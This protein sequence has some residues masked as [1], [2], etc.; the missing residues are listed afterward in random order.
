M[1]TVASAGDPS[2]PCYFRS[3]AKPFQA[4]PLL[5]SGAADAF[6]FTTQ[7][8]A[9]AAASHDGTARH[10]AIVSAM[11]AKAGVGEADLRCGY[12]P[13]IDETEKAKVALGLEPPSQVKCECS[14]EHAGMLAACRHRGWPTAT[15]N[16]PDHPLQREVLATV[17]A[18][19]GMP[20][21]G[22]TIATDGCGIPTFG[23]PLHAFA[24]AYAVLADP[25]QAPWTGPPELRAALVRMRD[26]M[27]A[28]P[29]MIAGDGNLDTDLMRLTEGRI[30]AKL[31]AEG[32]LCLAI[33]DQGLGIAISDAD[34]SQ[35]GLGPATV[36]V[37]EHLG[38]ADESTLA[39]LRAKHSGPVK[40]F[41]G[42]QVG[43]LLPVLE[44]RP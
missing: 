19:T 28:H 26:A 37:L 22:L 8:V 23:A 17:A 20:A 42:E 39:E 40:N 7:E 25:R 41:A 15:Y 38:L 1:T 6:G 18:V 11:L 4:M 16:D 29:D 31:G 36:A 3:S 30:V 5:T 10:Q 24:R 13:P 32:L 33:P 9:L 2:T 27:T 34:G 44:L 14:G 12:S 35:R 21:H 43:E